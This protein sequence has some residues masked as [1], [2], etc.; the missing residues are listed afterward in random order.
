MKKILFIFAFFCIWTMQSSAESA[1]SMKWSQICAGKMGAAWYG[2]D[3]AQQIAN[4][5][6]TIQRNSG[7][8]PKNVEMH[9]LSDSQVTQHY[10]ER[11]KQSCLDNTATTQEMRFLAKVYNKT[12]VTDY[13]VS[14]Q[15]A[16]NMIFKVEKARGGWSQYYPLSGNGSYHDYIT[17]NDDLVTNV[18]KLLRDIIEGKNEFAGLVDET[19]LERCEESFDRALNMIIN[20]QVD[21]NGTPSA[22][23]AQHDTTTLMPVEGRPHEL[24]SISGSESAALLSFLMTIDNPSEKL[25]NCITSAVEWLDAH[26]IPDKAVQDFTN[27]NGEKDRRLIDKSGSAVWGR[28]IQFGGAKAE[29]I[30]GSFFEKLRKRGK[31]RSYTTGGKTY[32][33]TEYEIATKSYKPEMAYQPIFA[34]YD[35]AYAN[36]FYRFMYSYE[37]QP[38]SID[39]R[40]CLVQTSLNAQRRTSYQF[41]GSWPLKVINT[42]YPKWARKWGTGIDAPLKNER[43]KYVKWVK[44]GRVLIRKNDMTYNTQGQIVN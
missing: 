23:C 4:V 7:G 20:C 44:G 25:R 21:D 29:E 5:V 37:D 33:Y 6:V 2:S 26:K 1:S 15:K 40:G 42:E 3:E 27:A 8:W 17:F 35:N 31:S 14:F 22:W 43:E 12:K 24:P 28:F 9:K 41:M 13:K 10:N 19:S 30:Y 11:N 36:L 39:W 16:L 38:D 34:I 32:T 18:M